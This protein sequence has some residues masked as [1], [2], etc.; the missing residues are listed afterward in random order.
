MLFRSSPSRQVPLGDVDPD[1]LPGEVLTLWEWAR[2]SIDVA[3]LRG[4]R[5]EVL[6]WLRQEYSS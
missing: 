2:D 5:N 4:T 6:H 1:A 3:S